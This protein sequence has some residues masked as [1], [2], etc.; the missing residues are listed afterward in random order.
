MCCFAY[1][2]FLAGQENVFYNM[3]I[4]HMVLLHLHTDGFLIWI[5]SS[6]PFILYRG[7]QF[8]LNC[9]YLFRVYS[10]HKQN[11]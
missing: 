6:K 8:I 9:Q 1:V 10:N 11:S 4:T 5:N 3:W 2:I 7:L